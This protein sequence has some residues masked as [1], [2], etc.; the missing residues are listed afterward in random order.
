RG[1]RPDR[2]R[3]G[4]RA[5]PSRTSRTSP[6]RPD[7]V[8]DLGVGLAVAH[9]LAHLLL[10]E[11]AEPHPRSMQE[12]LEL[13]DAHAALAGR[14]VVARWLGGEVEEALHERE[15][16]LPLSALELAPQ[17]SHGALHDR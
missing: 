16:P 4:A 2:R 6:E 10:H 3:A 1:G 7:E 15:G 17:S 14:V 9:R 12:G 13:G 11:L 5:A 8:V